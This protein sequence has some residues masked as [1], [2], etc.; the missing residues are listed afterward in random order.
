MNQ[1][2]AVIHSAAD[3]LHPVVAALRQAL[4]DDLVALVLFGSRARGD[5]R[6]E[7]DWDLLLIAENL[8]ASP[9]QRRKHVLSLLPADWRYRTNVVA[10]TPAEWFGRVTP[11]ALDIA[12]DGVVLYDNPR[13]SFTAHLTALHEQ[14]VHL[15]LER[16]QLEDGEWLWQWQ[17]EPQS[18]WRLEWTT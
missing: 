3:Q 5:E 16:R 13:H 17:G 15:G 8:P 14:L 9:L 12:L 1:L 18:D 11:L 4:G 7:S 6:P 2:T 10:H